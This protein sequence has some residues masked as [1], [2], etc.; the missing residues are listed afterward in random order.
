MTMEAPV[1]EPMMR[2][3]PDPAPAVEIVERDRRRLARAM[4]SDLTPSVPESTGTSEDVGAGQTGRT[5]HQASS[6][7]L[8][9]VRL[10]VAAAIVLIAGV[11]A[12]MTEGSMETATQLATT[13]SMRADQAPPTSVPYA[14]V[15]PTDLAA[16]HATP[17]YLPAGAEHDVGKPTLGGGWVDN[18]ALPG[19]VNSRFMPSSPSGAE[20][21]VWYHPA[22]GIA[23]TQLPQTM[24][25]FHGADERLVYI[26]TID[27]GGVAAMVVTPI[28]GYGVYR[29]A[30]VR[31]GVAY[32]LQSQRLKI[33]ADGTMSGVPVDEL[34]KVAQSIG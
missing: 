15:D 14:A 4:T 28:S 7:S 17:K 13:P 22:T 5:A 23:L 12:L 16:T 1:D 20:P 21:G 2:A 25:T 11:A 32:D 24:S 8:R 27:L 33:A 18:W 6:R 19:E 9:G 10:G 30:W 26:S 3:R 31:G 34:I 29:I